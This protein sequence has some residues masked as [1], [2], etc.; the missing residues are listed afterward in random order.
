MKAF[1]SSVV[2][3]ILIAIAAAVVLDR[4]PHD[5]ASSNRS[6]NANVRL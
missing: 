4:V 1:I 5:T 3:A 6:P 2:V